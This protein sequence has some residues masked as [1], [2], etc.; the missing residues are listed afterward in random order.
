[1]PSWTPAAPVLDARAPSALGR[2][3]LLNFAMV[4]A[5]GILYCI[6]YVSGR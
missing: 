2:G 4:E 1:V 3:A 6:M 5:T